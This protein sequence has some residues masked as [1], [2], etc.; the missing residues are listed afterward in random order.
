MIGPEELVARLKG[1]G[2]EFYAGVPDSLLQD[3]CAYIEDAA[4]I[5][6]ITANEGNAV[7][8][9]AGHYLAT[10]KPALVYMQ[11]S[12]LGNAV[13]PL[14]S[15]MDE[16]V[17]QIPV[18]LLVGW[19]GEPG[20]KDEPQHV[21]QGKITLSLLETMGID[22]T[23]LDEGSTVGN[24]WDQ[25]A[26][27]LS[28]KKPF[29]VVVKKGVFSPYKLRNVKDDISS[30]ERE[31]AIR[32]VTESLDAG[33]LVVATT[34]KISRELYEIREALGQNHSS[35]F[36][37]VGSMGHTSQIALGIA[38]SRPD[39]TVY[40]F[41]GDGSVLMHMGSLPVNAS[42]KV[43]NFRHLVFNNGAHDSVGG[44]PTVADEVSLAVIAKASGVDKVR[45]VSGVDELKE[46]LTDMKQGRL[47]FLEILVKKGSRKDLGR[48]AIPPRECKDNFR[49]LL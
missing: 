31:T 1:E 27:V 5:N 48:P 16:E 38:L 46:A 14:V 25:A 6:I 40:C 17:Y 3:F 36:L 45:T 32:I 12:G 49:E 18:L 8:L 29:A 11:N 2:I 4:P 33:D 43:E 22:Y 23:V 30:L 13:N 34:G 10:G 28:G 24:L 35:D 20:V 44:Q 37:T 7:G 42:L 39:K 9:A 47:Q 15:L 19:R 21:K 26:P 41:D